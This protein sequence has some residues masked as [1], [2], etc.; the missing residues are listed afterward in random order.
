MKPRFKKNPLGE[1]DARRLERAVSSIVLPF[2]KSPLDGVINN[3]ASS[4][5]KGGAVGTSYGNLLGAGTGLT[6]PT[7]APSS[8]S[9]STSI[10]DGIDESAVS[11][12]TPLLA[13]KPQKS[14]S[15]F[16]PAERT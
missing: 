5:N 15:F 14:V 6:K 3:G 11:A 13:S 9:A 12:S 16:V 4:I 1:R 10:N 8:S 7:T 2:R